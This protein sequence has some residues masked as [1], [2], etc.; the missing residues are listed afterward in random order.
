MIG[1]SGRGN[2][3]PPLEWKIAQLI[4]D[5]GTGMCVQITRAFDGSQNQYSFRVGKY[6]FDAN[7]GID[8]ILPNIRVFRSREGTPSQ[9]VLQDLPADIIGDLLEKAEDW[10]VEDMKNPVEVTSAQPRSQEKPRNERP[11]NDRPK[12]RGGGR[13]QHRE[14]RDRNRWED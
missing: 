7:E 9:P 4:K 8:K 5:D 11:L 6:Q 2:S 12:P 10:I 3:R 14:R 13:P 1:F